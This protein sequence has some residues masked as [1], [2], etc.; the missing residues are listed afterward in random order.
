MAKTSSTYGT[1]KAHT[2]S[3]DKFEDTVE[4]KIVEEVGHVGFGKKLAK[5]VALTLFIFG[6]LSTT[7]IKEKCTREK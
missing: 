7:V 4:E 5:Y 6:S 2:L 3:P 1:S